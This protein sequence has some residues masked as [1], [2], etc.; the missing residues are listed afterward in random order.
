M[1]AT[2]ADY[3]HLLQQLLPTGG[4]WP[5]AAG[6]TLTRLLNAFGYGLATAHNRALDAIEEADP[7]TTTELLSDWERVAG[8]PDACTAAVAPTVQERRAVLVARLTGRGG[9]SRQFFIDVAA[10]LGFAVTITEFRPFTS[11]HSAAGDPLTNGTWAFAWRVNAPE[12]TIVSFRAGQ[13]AAGEPLAKWGNEVL[14]C[15]LTRLKPAHT[16]VQ[17][18]YGG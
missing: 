1:R 13:S 14:E 5:R 9:Q 7:T 8:L 11:G 16:T 2:S 4:A 17:F 18:A 6:A 10:A 12:T 15:V 3:L